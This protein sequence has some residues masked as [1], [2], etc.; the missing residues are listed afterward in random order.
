M[1]P[2][3]NTIVSDLLLDRKFVCDLASCKGACCISGATGAPLEAAENEV[4]KENIEKIKPFMS[5]AGLASIKTQGIS[6]TNEL[7]EIFTSL[8]EEGGACSFVYF[9][10]QKTAKCAI[11]AAWNAK[12]I[13]FKKPISC[14]LYPVRVT[15]YVDFE[16][17]N[18][19]QRPECKPACKCGEAL[20]VKVY[21]FLKEPLIRKY[22]KEW[23][24][25]LE[26]IDMLSS[27]EV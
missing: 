1:I 20:N 9:D 7:G 13:D 4:I 21:Q 24:D 8:Q 18:Y 2:L 16:A 6:N 26:Q 5:L 12:K 14:H 25:E 17:V 10:A 22:G 3:R 15:K 23:F 11:E 19:D 27:S